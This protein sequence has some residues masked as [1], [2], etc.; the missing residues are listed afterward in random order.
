MMVADFSESYKLLVDLFSDPPRLAALL[1][2]MGLIGMLWYRAH[3][4]LRRRLWQKAQREAEATLEPFKRAAKARHL[5]L[6][7]LPAYL[8]AQDQAVRSQR[9]QL[10]KATGE[11]KGLRGRLGEL[12][13]RDAE[14][15]P[16]LEQVEQEVRRLQQEAHAREERLR[17]SN[18][19]R[20]VRQGRIDE[21]LGLDIERAKKLEKLEAEARQHH[22]STQRWTA[23]VQQLQQDLQQRE[24]EARQANEEVGALR[25]RFA[26]EAQ[27]Q[28]SAI[29]T[30]RQ[31]VQTHLQTI[32]R[33][34]DEARARNGSTQ[35]LE[36]ERARLQQVLRERDAA[37]QAAQGELVDL[38]R[39][40][41]AHKQQVQKHEATIER[42]RQ[43]PP[44]PAQP[45]HDV[46]D[47][48]ERI[49]E[50]AVPVGSAPPFC[51]L[52]PRKTP[53]LAVVNLKGGVGKTTIT[54]NLGA[55]LW[56]EAQKALLIDL[57]F[58][59]SLTARCLS[60]RARLDLR[61]SGRYAQDFFL[62]RPPAP[63]LSSA[64]LSRAT[65]VSFADCPEGLIELERQQGFILPA[66]ERLADIETGLMIRWLYQQ[67]T[68]D[69]RFLLRQ[70][71]HGRAVWQQFRCVLI[72]CPPRLTTACVN[73]LACS[74]YVLIPV[75]L[76]S[77]STERVPTLLEW[78]Q[79]L[80]KAGVCPG[81]K[82]VT[83]LANRVGRNKHQAQA[84]ANLP[85]E[86]AGIWSGAL[87]F[88][89]TQIHDDSCF[90]EASARNWPAVLRRTKPFD[91][92]R[93]NFRDVLAEFRELIPELRGS[94]RS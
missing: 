61:N 29:S 67:G 8:D 34:Q 55:T 86:C 83:V 57:D 66:D 78:L 84:W 87:I 16:R 44:N 14:R 37:L 22:E 79:R 68:T 52:G 50:R 91:G 19:A 15:G 21:L 88:L 54:A 11:V 41:A 24:A 73:A 1:L 69:V 28:A 59:A 7:D 63:D 4:L 80:H 58:Q 89:R 70:A 43:A 81:L 30:L 32:Q 94:N 53:V 17:E 60:R 20:A 62:N 42:L 65:E 56:T 48:T 10:R 5:S 13:T 82:G 6:E 23:Q 74:D 36:A 40:A 35:G 33:L 45:P 46:V 75:L 64:L 26:R 49:W 85:G 92:I 39:Q 93:S 38:Q 51:P 27:E 12:E 2:G 3:R 90:T 31:E 25:E 18:E 72:D 77:T 9:E 47:I 76:D 71:L